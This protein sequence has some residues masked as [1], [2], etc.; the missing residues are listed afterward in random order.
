MGKTAR[1]LSRI[2][3][4]SRAY[5][6]PRVTVTSNM[7]NIKVVQ[8]LLQVA[9]KAVKAAKGIPT[10]SRTSNSLS[11]TGGSGEIAALKSQV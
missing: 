9:G 7:G 2:F 1:R 8:Y 6:H 10:P 11:A 5:Y 3:A 4:Q